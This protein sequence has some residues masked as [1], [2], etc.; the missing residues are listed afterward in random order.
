VQY[1]TYAHVISGETQT[2][3]SSLDE[4]A[5]NFRRVYHQKISHIKIPDIIG[6]HSLA[7]GVSKTVL[8]SIFHI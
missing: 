1:D 2:T 3:S 5:I 4:E 6:E 8:S 7:T